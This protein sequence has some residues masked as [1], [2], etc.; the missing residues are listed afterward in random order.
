[1]MKAIFARWSRI[2]A[3]PRALS[4]WA[5]AGLYLVLAAGL[6]AA[7]FMHYREYEN[8]YVR[9]MR[10]QIGAVANLKVRELANYRKER[11]EDADFFM[12]NATF[13]AL[14]RR[15]LSDVN[16]RE[17]REQLQDWLRNVAKHE[18]YDQVR[19]MDARGVTRLSATADAGPSSPRLVRQAR[20]VLRTGRP[21]F[22]DFHR[23]E[24]DPKVYLAVLVP[25]FD[26]KNEGRPLGVVELRIDAAARIFPSLHQW[27][28]PSL[29]AESMLF[30]REGGYALVLNELRF[31]KDSALRLR[32]P[33]AR[34]AEGLDYRG[35]PAVAVLLAVPGSPWFLISRMDAAEVYGPLEQHVE[36]LVAFVFVLLFGLGAAL[37]LLWRRHIEH[38]EEE[39]RRG[40]AALAEVQ[41][42]LAQSEVLFRTLTELSTVGIYRTDAAG[43]SVYVNDRGCEILGL[44]RESAL[45]DGWASTL[46]PEDRER[47]FAAWE[48]ARTNMSPFQSEHRFQR[49]DGQVGWVVV[50]SQPEYGPDGDVLGHVGTLIDITERKWMETSLREGKRRYSDLV[51][52]LDEMVFVVAPNCRF[53][54]VNK[55]WKKVL[56]YGDEE[57]VLMDLWEIVAPEHRAQY[58]EFFK[59]A[60]GAVC[61]RTVFVAK[62]GSTLSVEV[63]ANPIIEEGLIVGWSCI[64]RDI[65]LQERVDAERGRADLFQSMGLFAGG[66]AH[67]FNNLLT[68]ILAN[69]SQART[70]LQLPEEVSE[71]IQESEA[72]AIRAKDLA[73]RLLTFSKG[74]DP[75]KK[76]LSPRGVLWDAAGLALSGSNIK[77]DFD[78]AED[79]GLI[80]ADAAQF[81][82][83]VSNLVINARQAMF[84]GGT[85]AIRARNLELTAEDAR[86]HPALRSGRH[87]RI[88]IEDQGVGI[89][90]D[91]MAHIFDPYFTT[92]QGGSGL[93]LAVSRSIVLRHGG[94][95]DVSSTPGK[96]T[97][98]TILL[99]ALRHEER[100]AASPAAPQAVPSGSGRVLIMDDERAIRKIASR[101]LTSAGYEVELAKE[102][103]EAVAM[104]RA[105]E[106]AGRAYRAV[107]LDMTVP[108][109]MGGRAAMASLRAFAPGVKAIVSTGYSEEPVSDYL[110]QGF[111]VYL[112][113]PYTAADLTRAMHE[114]LNPA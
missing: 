42:S 20:E 29:T 18:A 15:A 100:E 25:V 78:V 60:Q 65:G 107:I 104:F 102:G 17:A 9:G 48:L 11:L 88:E 23:D 36:L 109:G 66:V 50:Q 86:L 110:E 89:A 105:A 85:I 46:H 6:G 111:S 43:I 76:T 5:L 83:V 93:G 12:D 79:L 21:F 38:V 31:S 69:L 30:R 44:S 8:E 59:L 28:T 71:M 41:K 84:A 77:L 62:N 55:A 33:L 108:G 92:K 90:A 39:R 103:A 58:F 45:G 81:G 13:A 56:G 22:V 73:R 95:L 112:P 64:A 2:R 67:D 91:V 27:P 70:S 106:N 101:I 24:G 32:L 57:F 68:G 7:V 16:D 72:G 82:Q 4:A 3:D 26:R 98:F 1:M 94:S 49:P 52:N 80:C 114:L 10:D 113:K 35:V 47:V 96:G 34:R 61:G 74:G 75:V 53:Q 99:P 87:I 54:F 40:Q 37:A 14:A 63:H 97:V 19:F 51:E